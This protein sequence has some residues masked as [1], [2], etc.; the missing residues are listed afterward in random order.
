MVDY[1]SNYFLPNP[2][3]NRYKTLVKSRVFSVKT[4]YE[5]PALPLS[6]AAKFNDYNKLGIYSYTL[7]LLST[8]SL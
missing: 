3:N 5:S 7:N 1:A 6:Y 2:V 4:T 8:S